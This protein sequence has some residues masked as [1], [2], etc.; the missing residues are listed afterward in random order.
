MATNPSYTDIGYLQVNVTAQ[1]NSYP[2]ENAKIQ[3]RDTNEP[4]TIIEEINTGANGESEV[5]SLNTPPL[6]YS[7]EPESN[8]PYAKYDIRIIAEGYESV[9]I[10]GAEILSGETA[11]QN[12]SLLP[13]AGD[14]ESTDELFVIPDHTL[15][16]EYPPKI[17]EDEIKTVEQ[18]GEI[19]LSRVVIPEYVIVHDG[20]PSDSSAKNYYVKYKDYIKNVASSEIY[21]TWPEN[22]I[23]ANILAI[24]SI[25]LNRVYTEWYRNRGYNFTI[26]SSTAY[27]QKWIPERNIYKNIS[28]AVDAIFTNYLSRPNVTQPLFTQ[29]CDGQQ[30]S[31]PGWMRQWESKTLGEQGLSTIEILRSFYG[32]SIYINASDEIS[33]IPSSFPGSNLTNGSRGSKVRQLQQQINAIAK[34]YPQVPTVAVDGIYGPKT[35]DAVKNIQRIFGLP[36]TGITDYPTWYKISEIYVGVTRIAETI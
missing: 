27:D 29:F 9:D 32:S 26:T 33:G 35:A 14:S 21:A 22:T 4:D 17:P 34:A 30:V 3:I 8:M 2:I 36:Q 16:E 6:E 19:V 15:Y 25:T 18:T 13:A 11:L 31:C 10:A 12:T 7:L 28:S 5:I 1:S 23:F 24:Q 20:P